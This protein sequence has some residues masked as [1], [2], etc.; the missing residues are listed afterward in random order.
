M[1]RELT[2]EELEQRVSELEKETVERKQV[3]E[4]LRDATTLHF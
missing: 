1:A 4:A 2:Y 3:E